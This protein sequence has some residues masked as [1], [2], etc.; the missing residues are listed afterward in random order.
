MK[1]APLKFT[2]P[3]LHRLAHSDKV[4]T[5][6]LRAF[7]CDIS[8]RM[9]VVA[10]L[11]HGTDLNHRPY[12]HLR[13]QIIRVLPDF[14]L[15]FGITELPYRSGSEPTFDAFYEFDTEQLSELVR[16]GYFGPRFRVPESMIG[17]VWE[18]PAVTDFLVVSPEG[19]EHP[20]VVFAGVRDQNSA[21]LDEEGSGYTLAEYFPD[22]TAENSA[23][24]AVE[25]RPVVPTRSEQIDDLFAGEEDLN[26]FPR[27]Q[28]GVDRYAPASVRSAAGQVPK[29]VFDQVLE[30]VEAQRQG[31]VGEPG[32]DYA[33]NSPEALR[34]RVR[35]ALPDQYR[36]VPSRA[37]PHA[38]QGDGDDDGGFLDLDD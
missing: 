5:Q 12:L 2:D 29:S 28:E 31:G 4:R 27:G 9:E 8:V 21:E 36:T 26:E 32:V 13:G 34:E 1:T 33:P 14:P 24:E 6:A 10:I 35:G 20:P 11:H 19:P 15:P 16:K 22:F 3:W 30:E 38:A 25:S 17:I 37:V 7:P 18:L 23:Q